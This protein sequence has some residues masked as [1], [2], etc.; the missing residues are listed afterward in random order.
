[1]AGTAAQQGQQAAHQVRDSKALEVGVRVGLV[2]YGVVHLLIAWIALQIAWG[3]EKSSAS[4]SGALREMADGTIGS[5][6]LWVVALGLVALVIWQVGEAIWGYTYEE[7]GKRLAQRLASAGRAVIYAALA[8]SAFNIVT[9]SAKSGSSTDSMTADLMK[10]TGGQVLVG[11]VGLGIVVVG[12]VLV[13]RGFTASFTHHL[14]PQATSGSSGNVVVRLGQAGYVAK[15]VSLGIIGGLFVWAAW[16]F[17]PQKAGGLDVALTTLLDQP[18]GPYLLTL[19]A[20]GIAA[21]GAY[22]FAWARYPRE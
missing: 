3:T 11:L 22:C 1:M 8:F 16:T 20:L 12:V 5:I 6:L 17:D 18:F 14:Q 9:G 19:V 10:M 13:V 2:S 4:S 7:G 21:Y 15:G